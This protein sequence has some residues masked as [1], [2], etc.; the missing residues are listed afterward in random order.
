VK[1]EEAVEKFY[2][3]LEA[4]GPKAATLKWYRHR[5]ARFLKAFGERE[6]SSVS[7]DDVRAYI[8]TLRGLDCSAHSFFSMVRV[9][10]RVFKWLYEERRIDDGFCKRI[11]APKLPQLPSKAVD[12]A[13]VRAMLK[14]A[15]GSPIGKRDKAIVLFLLDT[16]CRVG[17][18]CGMRTRDVDLKAGTALVMEKGGKVR[19]VL[20]GEATA[21]AIWA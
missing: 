3:A 4:D 5:L 16:G 19:T 8:V 7:I 6:V 14:V 1:V 21:E 20:F 2:V 17:G 10:R 13:D 11:K 9:V 12:I 15:A 18:L